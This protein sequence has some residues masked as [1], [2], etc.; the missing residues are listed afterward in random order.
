MMT[1]GLT[2]IRYRLPVSSGLSEGYSLPGDF[3]A[4]SEQR[5]LAPLVIYL[6]KYKENRFMAFP[7]IV[8]VHLQ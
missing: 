8:E 5:N 6:V 1:S 3:C 7:L 4:G 2:V